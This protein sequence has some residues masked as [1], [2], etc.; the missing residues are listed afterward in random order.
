MSFIDP[1]LNWVLMF[2]PF[3]SILIISIIMS[4]ISTFAYKFASDQKKIKSLKEKTK[5]IQKQIKTVSRE[6]HQKA[7]KLNS[8][9]MKLNGPLMKESMKSTIWTL[10]PA[11]IIITWMSANL[12]FL[13]INPNQEFSIT[14]EFNEGVLDNV[15]MTAIPDN[16]EFINGNVQE[17]V[18]NTA[19]WKLK[20]S[21]E[22]KY[23]F[24]IDYRDNS[25]E[26][27]VLVT[28]SRAYIQPE[29]LIKEEGFKEIV[30]SNEK[31]KPLKGIPILQGL[32]WLWTYILLSMILTTGL[33]KLLKVY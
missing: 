25:Y 10:I 2:N 9:L 20:S 3:I 16:V 15:S 7:M 6:N 8:E 29:K 13:P 22:N 33:R 32:N 5:E 23:K 17:I 4:I 24:I 11:L 12:V 26:Q 30:V 19:T 18:D 27:E 21:E 31:I 1:A 14:A 28:T